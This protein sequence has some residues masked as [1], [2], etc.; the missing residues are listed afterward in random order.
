MKCKLLANPITLD[1]TKQEHPMEA[2]FLTAADGT[3]AAMMAA[4]FLVL[5][6]IG[7]I[8][9]MLADLLFG[10]IDASDGRQLDLGSDARQIDKAAR[11]FRSGECRRALCLCH[12]IIASNGQYASTAGTL[13]HWI[14]NP[15]TLRIFNPPRTTIRLKERDSI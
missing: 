5:L 11:L 10:C 9:G 4:A 12:G 6:W 8:R 15:G 7:T 2:T 3:V 14:N 13:V 1:T